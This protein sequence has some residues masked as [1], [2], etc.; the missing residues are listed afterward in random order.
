MTAGDYF[1]SFF[2]LSTAAQHS[3]A[4]SRKPKVTLRGKKSENKTQ[5]YNLVRLIITSAVLSIYA[6]GVC[7]FSRRHTSSLHGP[8]NLN[9]SA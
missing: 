4:R 6:R 9:G 3:T 5:L 7:L 8:K 2:P 1:F